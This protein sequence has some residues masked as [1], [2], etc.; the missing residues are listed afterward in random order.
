MAIDTSEIV[1]LIWEKEESY[2][3]FDFRDPMC[4]GFSDVRSAA[5]TVV[6]DPASIGSLHGQPSQRR[7]VE[8][9]LTRLSCQFRGPGICE[10]G[11]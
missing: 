8:T 7:H 1:P 9:R 10:F 6:N 11:C 3:K 4:K 2:P 5:S